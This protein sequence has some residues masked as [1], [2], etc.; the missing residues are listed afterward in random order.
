[1]KKAIVLVNVGTPKKADKK[2]V[3]IFL[4]QFLNDKRVIDIPFFFRLLLVNLI[5]IPFRVSKSTKLYQKLW[6]EKGSPILYY[7]KSLS[8]KLQKIVPEN[9]TIFYAMRYGEPSLISV[10]EKLKIQDFKELIFLPLFPQYAS[11]T[12]GSINEL[13]LKELSNNQKFTNLK[14][15]NQFYNHRAFL[16]AFVRQIQK[17]EISDFEHVIFSY[18]GLPIRQINKIHPK[19]FEKNCTCSVSMPEHGKYCY[20]ATCYETTRLLAQIL[21]LSSDMYSVGFQ[22]RL[23]KN[24]LYPFTDKI[25]I[26]KAQSGIKNLLIISPSF[27]TDCLETIVEIEYE[28]RNIFIENGGKNLTLV[29][30][31]NDNTFWA[32]AINEIIHSL[33]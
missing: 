9:E 31:L 16:N 1:M 5:I 14:I 18:H 4:R 22:S 26:E 24:W 17:Y 11:S 12:T 7:L 32:E 21:N 13:I 27:V 8:V 19:H 23:D 2:S 25:I 3:K 6:T 15:I 28:Y 10:L 33:S 20:K 29:K 30:S